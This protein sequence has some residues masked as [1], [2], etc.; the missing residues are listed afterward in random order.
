MLTRAAKALRRLPVFRPAAAS[1]RQLPLRAT[2]STAVPS[3]R[4][5]YIK[6]AKIDYPY[7]PSVSIGRGS[8]RESPYTELKEGSLVGDFEVEQVSWLELYKLRVYEL[9]H[10]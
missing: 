3:V 2:S 6:A 10:R 9:R 5:S 1:I 8:K 4:G 7:D